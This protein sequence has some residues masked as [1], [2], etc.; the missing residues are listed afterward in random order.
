MLLNR[1]VKLG[2]LMTVRELVKNFGDESHVSRWLKQ[3]NTSGTD[4]VPIIRVIK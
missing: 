2:F 4:S 3:T 1:L